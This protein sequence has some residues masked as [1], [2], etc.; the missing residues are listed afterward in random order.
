MKF[1]DKYFMKSG[2]IFDKPFG[3]F[4]R[5][6]MALYQSLYWDDSII[7]DHFANNS[8]SRPPLRV[9]YLLCTYKYL[10]IFTLARRNPLMVQPSTLIINHQNPSQFVKRLIGHLR[11]IDLSPWY[12]WFRSWIICNIQLREYSTELHVDHKYRSDCYN[13]CNPDKNLT[14]IFLFIAYYALIKCKYKF[15]KEIFNNKIL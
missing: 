1:E 15:N 9:T 13:T 8:R 5:T 6:S 3:R 12:G 2:R 10:Q 7:T 11:P 14:I 4:H